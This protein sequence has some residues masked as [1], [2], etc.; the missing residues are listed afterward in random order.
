MA[1][2][3]VAVKCVSLICWYVM[4]CLDFSGATDCVYRCIP[5]P[6]PDGATARGGP[7]PPLQCASRFRGLLW[8]FVTIIFLKG[9]VVSLT[10]NPQPGGPGYPLLSGPSPSTCP[11]RVALP[12]ANATADIALR[13]IWPHEPSHPASA[14][15]KVEVPW[16]GFYS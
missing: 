12:V 9:E 11:A 16:R 7:W 13:I 8:G 14:S 10:P 3:L 15:D 4:L 5:P 2:H 1:T 6:S